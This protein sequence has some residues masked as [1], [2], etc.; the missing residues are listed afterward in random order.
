M[1]VYYHSLL[2]NQCNS[3][4]RTGSSK[5]KQ[6]RTEGKIPQ[7]TEFVW[8]Y[9]TPANEE[10]VGILL[11]AGFA[12]YRPLHNGYRYTCLRESAGVEKKRRAY[13]LARMCLVIQR[14]ERRSS[15]SKQGGLCTNPKVLQRTCKATV[16]CKCSWPATAGKNEI[17]HKQKLYFRVTSKWN[18][19]NNFCYWYPK[20]I[21]NIFLF[22]DLIWKTVY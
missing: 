4:S 14:E 21:Q 5:V 7:I 11:P 15:Q 22:M 9:H 6:V 2:H 13:A 16:T 12:R 1:T 8:C 19:E 17:M 20:K 10:G 18:K 3:L